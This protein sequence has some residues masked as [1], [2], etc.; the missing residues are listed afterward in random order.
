MRMH[1]ETHNQ[2][3]WSRDILPFRTAW[4]NELWREI[5]TS[6]EMET[7]PSGVIFG[8]LGLHGIGSTRECEL[9]LSLGLSS[10]TGGIRG[11]LNEGNISGVCLLVR[12]EERNELLNR[13]NEDGPRKLRLGDGTL[14]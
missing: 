4:P 13:D 8:R 6:C 7:F 3:G 1:T 5:G 11:L 14:P 12:E 9:R 2:L 10:S